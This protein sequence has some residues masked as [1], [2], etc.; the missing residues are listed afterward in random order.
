VHW[1]GTGSSAIQAHQPQ[2]WSQPP[3]AIAIEY[4]PSVRNDHVGACCVPVLPELLLTQQADISPTSHP[5]LT[6]ISPSS[7]P[8]LTH[9]SPTSLTHISPTS[10]PHLTHI[11]P[12]SHPHLTHISPTSLT[13][14]SHPHLTHISPTSHPQ[15]LAAAC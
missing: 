8:H 15:L 12:T 2:S 13:H 5:H 1:L 14:I 11:S 4:S 3:A 7:H 9:I 6:H 10:H